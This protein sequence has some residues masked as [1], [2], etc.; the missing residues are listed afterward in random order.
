M[1]LT[2]LNTV[3]LSN[4]INRFFPMSG[5]VTVNATVEML[6][7]PYTKSV[8]V[9][10]DIQK[11]LISVIQARGSNI[12]NGNLYVDGPLNPIPGVADLNECSEPQLHDC[13]E[14]ADCINLFGGYTCQCKAGYGDRNEDD[15]D[16]AGRFCESCSKDFC[17]G[18]G[19]CKIELGEKVCE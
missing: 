6:A 1:S 8:V 16:K 10:R 15:D 9:K 7:S 13:H 19:E 12:G 3:Y 2:D 11:K 18:R 4:S 5:K 17:Y 14:Y